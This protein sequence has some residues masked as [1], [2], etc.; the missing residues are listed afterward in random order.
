MSAKNNVVRL[1]NGQ[2]TNDPRLDRVRHVD[3]RSL[4][5]SVRKVLPREAYRKPRSYTW[6]VEP[7]LDQGSEGACVGFGFAHELA[8]RPAVVA[9]DAKFAREEIYWEA[10]KI[11]EWPGGSYPGAKPVSEGSSVLA[12]AKV[13]KKDGYYD[14]YRWALKFDDL[15]A[16]VGYKGPVVIGVDWY[17][18]MF[19][20]DGAGFIHPTG[21]IEGG[22]CT[23]MY[24]VRI[25]KKSNGSVNFDTSYFGIH[26][27]WGPGWGEQGRC[28]IS[29]T[30][31]MILWPGG[32]FCI[33]V[34]RHKQ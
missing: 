26:N 25:N 30:E 15:I 33:P 34:G 2:F 4:N 21:K 12:G 29:F 6:K 8:A 24:Q 16:A 3:I 20:P 19:E 1:K 28:K 9:V 5:Y 17:T 32:D 27:S 23:L 18:G 10:Q 14:E 13:L 22:H 11:D 7:R 31:V